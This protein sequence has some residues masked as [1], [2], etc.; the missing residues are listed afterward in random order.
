MEIKDR[1]TR[2]AVLTALRD[3]I[4]EVIQGERYELTGELIE[5]AE[6]FGVK[7]LD[8]D[9]PNGV[10]VA[11]A[12][13]ATPEGKAVV[14]DERGFLN[15]VKENAPTE[16]VETVRDTYQKALLSRLVPH[17]D[18]AVDTKSGVIVTG[19][20]FKDSAPRLTV[21][22]KTDGRE[23]IANAFNRNE[24]DDVV[25]PLGALEAKELTYSAHERVGDSSTANAT[26]EPESSGA[27]GG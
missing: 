7:A 20:M 2:V 23:E 16:V 12:S 26:I 17:D 14:K 19:V 15:W 25:R 21:R 11:S 6:V 10:K 4:D 9:L 1:A 22:F 3:S 24:L 18:G 5:L 13:I 8:I 27:L